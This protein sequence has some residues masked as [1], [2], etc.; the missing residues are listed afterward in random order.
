MINISKY[1]KV[2]WLSNFNFRVSRKNFTSY[3]NPYVSSTPTN[4]KFSKRGYI[5]SEYIEDVGVR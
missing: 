5:D 2:R 4:S 1:K 3:D